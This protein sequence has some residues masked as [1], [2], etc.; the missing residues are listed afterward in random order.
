M[1]MTL[2][3]V[4]SAGTAAKAGVLTSVTLI[5]KLQA[6]GCVHSMQHTTIKGQLISGQMQYAIE[7]GGSTGAVVVRTGDT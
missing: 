1:W 7:Q 6:E 3:T 4:V 2:T 5:V